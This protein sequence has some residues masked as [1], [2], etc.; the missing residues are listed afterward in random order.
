M[1]FSF[2]FSTSAWLSALGIFA[3]RVCDTSADTV[4]VVMVV[5]GRKKE[6]WF[7]AFLGTLV[8]VVAISS[9]LTHLD[10]PLN[11]VGYA[12]GYATG[13]VVG[14]WIEQLLAIGYTRLTVVSAALGS[15]I[16]ANLRQNGFAVTEIPATGKDGSVCILNC[17][18]MRKLVGQAQKVIMD[19]DPNAFI[20]AEDVKPIHRGFW[21]TSKVPVSI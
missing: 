10:N 21:R 12:A 11:A 17:S 13:N 14:M 15:D 4:R 16:A 3:L 20:T 7:L 8:F 18:L 19:T 2:L 6:A 5:R 9:V 1:D